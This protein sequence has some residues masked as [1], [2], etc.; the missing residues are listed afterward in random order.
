LNVTT[1]RI[2]TV[3]ATLLLA[4]VLGACSG[5]G[6][7]SFQFG[8]GP[9]DPPADPTKFPADYKPEVAD[10]MRRNIDNPTKIR[11]A[12][13]AKP[14]LK[15]IGKNQ[16]YVTCVRYNPRDSE[17]KYEGPRQSV[18]I[19]LS[20]GLNQFLPD[21]PQLCAGLTYERYPEIENMVP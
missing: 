3:V 1:G 19:F 7:S 14:V 20:G 9:V 2:F 21:D 17:G 16:Q 13:I 11:D 8:K 6:T 18:A 12:Y 15:P 4:G 10:F 5:S